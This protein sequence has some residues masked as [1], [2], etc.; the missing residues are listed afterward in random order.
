MAAWAGVPCT[1]G[2]GEQ[3]EGC[4]CHRRLHGCAATAGAH[5]LGK[6]HQLPRHHHP[7]VLHPLGRHR[8]SSPN[9]CCY[10]CCSTSGTARGCVV[11]RMLKTGCAGRRDPSSAP[12]AP[13][14]VPEAEGHSTAG[15]PPCHSWP[16]AG[17]ISGLQGGRRVICQGS[18]ACAVLHR[19]SC[20]M[21]LWATTNP[22]L[23]FRVAGSQGTQQSWQAQ[24]STLGPGPPC[25][26]YKRMRWPAHSL[27][28]RAKT[29]SS[30][31]PGSSGLMVCPAL[32]NTTC[33]YSEPLRCT[34]CVPRFKKC[35]QLH[36]RAFSVAGRSYLA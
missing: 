4:V 28:A 23:P 20:I 31:Y 15:S 35:R 17:R 14:W 2:L 36:E 11:L 7:S 29:S 12:C 9:C 10:C 33:R 6:R 3:V 5:A 32:T 30:L 18:C 8:R 1:P 13:S 24:A 34:A 26:W 16:L 27:K 25:A 22:V 21:R 19:K